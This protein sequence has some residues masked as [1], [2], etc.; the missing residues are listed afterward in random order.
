MIY[1][2]AVGNCWGGRIGV[3]IDDLVA[4]LF[5]FANYGCDAAEDTFALEGAGFV[6]A[7]EDFG[8]DNQALAGF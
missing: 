1:G 7:V 3:G 4:A 2:S 6:V 8:V 5:A